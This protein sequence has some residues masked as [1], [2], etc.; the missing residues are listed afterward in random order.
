MKTDWRRRFGREA[1]IGLEDADRADFECEVLREL[2]GLHARMLLRLPW[3]Q[4]LLALGV[5]LL[6]YRSTSWSWLV[7]WSLLTVGAECGRA[8][9]AVRVLRMAP[10]ADP[11]TIHRVFIGLAAGVGATV[12][13]SA[14]LFIPNMPLPDRA[15]LVIVLFAMPAAGVSVAVS[16]PRILAAYSLLIMV[17]TAV[18]WAV[19]YPEQSLVVAGLT[20]LYWS[21]IVSV[22]GDGEQLLRRSVAIRRER[23]RTL[24]D[25]QQ[26]NAEVRAAVTRAEASSRARARV[27][28]AASHDLRQPLHALSVYSAVLV[29]NPSAEALPE[30][31]GNIDRLVRNLGGL[32]HGLLDLSRLSADQYVP[33]LRRISL[34]RLAAEVCSEFDA[35]A[36]DKSLR[37]VRCLGQVR[38]FDD[39]V[40]IARIVRNLLDNA[41][42]YTEQGEVV[43]STARRDEWA[44]LEI[45][46]T[47]RGIPPGELTRVFEEFYQLDN[48]GRDQQHGVGLGLTIVQRLCELIGADMAL[49]SESGVGTRVTL[50]FRTLA[51]GNEPRP[52]N[53]DADVSGVSGKR[54]Y[55]VDDEADILE[56]MR[57]LLQGWGCRVETA[58]SARVADAL[59]SDVGR[60]D[61]LIVDLRL[62]EGEQG[63]ALVRRLR[64]RHGEFP[65]LVV[66]GETGLEA[67]AP[68]RVAGFPLLQKPIVADV[69]YDA[70]SRALPS[71][72]VRQRD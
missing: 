19:Q 24:A 4:A 9:Y 62:A 64:G 18:C 68:V 20:T 72:A 65:V 29:A 54:I 70:V 58:A 32:L 36:E 55:V 35:L 43:V 41:I 8:L 48:P 46:D 67:L 17:P 53:A 42:K 50:R 34:D 1:A 21:F 30:V 12:G 60:P 13:L 56:A 52:V 28:A 10:S 40:A 44:V 27:L 45:V 16:S 71:A 14:W 59:F 39:P 2:I 31:A 47:G 57:I 38:L 49:A 69:L 63:L 11:A 26:L 6:A 23:D 15:L 61:L 25:L 5:V 22:A 51:T 7:G 37:L 66:T 3:V 33:E